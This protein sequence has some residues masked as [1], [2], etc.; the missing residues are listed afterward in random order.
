VAPGHDIVLVAADG[1][2]DTIVAETPVDRIAGTYASDGS[3][4]WWAHPVEEPETCCI[5]LLDADGNLTPLA[6]VGWPT[7]SPD[8]R[9]VLAGA[10]DDVI[11]ASGRD[12]LVRVLARDGS[13][14]ATIPDVDDDPVWQRLAP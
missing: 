3:I 4:A 1:S 12:S 14:V 9:R 2:G 10:P 5:E 11:S 6:G 7:F 8:G 13:V